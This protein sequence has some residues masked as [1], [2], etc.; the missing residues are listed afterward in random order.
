MHTDDRDHEIDGHGASQQPSLLLDGSP[1]YQDG[2]KVVDGLKL[3]GLADEVDG[4]ADKVDG[5]INGSAC[6]L[7]AALA[8]FDAVHGL[9]LVTNASDGTK[10]T[11]Q[12]CFNSLSILLQAYSHCPESDPLRSFLT[13]INFKE[14][15]DAWNA[16]TEVQDQLKAARMNQII[17]LFNAEADR[18]CEDLIKRARSRGT[19][20][21]PVF[22]DCFYYAFIEDRDFVAKFQTS[23]CVCSSTSPTG[24]TG[25]APS[26]PT[27]DSSAE[28]LSPILKTM[29]RSKTQ[30][31]GMDELDDGSTI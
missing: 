2:L 13:Q 4:L 5:I 18:E 1:A 21:N 19:I 6:A 10:A 11:L 27:Y 3:D 9:Q 25:S 31:H 14:A 20:K 24:T 12:S 15:F 7:G 22:V 8:A 17:T 28:R 26:F 23:T 30:L 16:R 29:K